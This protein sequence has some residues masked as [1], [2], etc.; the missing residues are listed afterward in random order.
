MVVSSPEDV[1]KRQAL[2]YASYFR[3]ADPRI[4]GIV[5]YLLRVEMPDH[6]WNCEFI[7][8]ATHSSMHTTISVL[9]GLLEYRRWA[10]QEA[11][12]LE[13]CAREDVYKRQALDSTKMRFVLRVLW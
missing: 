13:G 1:Y 11:T 2:G 8:G 4:H 10:E 5:D 7:H 6:G 3:V 12:A 9:E